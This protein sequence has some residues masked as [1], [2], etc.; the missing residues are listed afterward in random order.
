MASARSARYY[1]GT[2]AA[3]GSV[4]MSFASV[5]VHLADDPA[6]AQRVRVAL[7]LAKTHD[8]SVEGLFVTP[9]LKDMPLGFAGR[10]AAGGYLGALADAYADRA[11]SS[12]K[13]FKDLTAGTTAVWRKESG[14]KCFYVCRSSKSPND[15]LVWCEW[16]TAARAKKFIKSA[17]LRKRMKEAGVTSKPEISMWDKMEVLSV[18]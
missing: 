4:A 13:R 16:D 17:E 3:Q 9:S 2:K 11:T 1:V 6:E 7:A 14:E 10:A 5:L 15:L 12:E 18:T 8:A